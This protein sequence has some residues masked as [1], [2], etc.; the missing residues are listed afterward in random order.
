MRRSRQEAQKRKKPRWHV[1]KEPPF[2]VPV[3]TET[4]EE[5]SAQTWFYYTGFIE[6]ATVVVRHSGDMD[7]LYKMGFFGKGTLSRSEPCFAQRKQKVNLRV[8]SSTS[9]SQG[10][11]VTFNTMLAPVMNKRTYLAHCRYKAL[12]EGRTS[13]FNEISYHEEQQ[14]CLVDSSDE[15]EEDDDDDNAEDE[16]DDYFLGAGGL[17]RGFDPGGPRVDLFSVTDLSTLPLHQLVSLLSQVAILSSEQIATFMEVPYSMADLERKFRNIRSS[18]LRMLRQL[19]AVNFPGRNFKEGEV[20][21]L[22]DDSPTKSGGRRAVGG[23]DD[24]EED[25]DDDDDEDAVVI[26]DSDDE[27]DE[28]EEDSPG[29]SEEGEQES[30]GGGDGKRKKDKEN[31]EEGVGK[32]KEPR[33]GGWSDEEAGDADFWGVEKTTVESGSL[34]DGKKEGI[35]S[36]SSS[37]FGKEGEEKEEATGEDVKALDVRVAEKT[38]VSPGEVGGRER[39]ME[40]EDNSIQRGMEEDEG[41]RGGSRSGG[42]AVD[43]SEGG[44]TDK[45][46]KGDVA[47]ATAD[48]DGGGKDVGADEKDGGGGREGV[49]DDVGRGSGVAADDKGGVKGCEG[50]GVVKDDDSGG[51]GGGGA[52]K[53]EG[54]RKSGGKGDTSKG[55]G[56]DNDDDTKEEKSSVSV[57]RSSG[58]TDRSSK[59]KDGSENDGEGKVNGSS[60]SKSSSSGGGEL[61]TDGGGFESRKVVEAKQ[62]EDAGVSGK[63]QGQDGKSPCRER[64]VDDREKKSNG[65]CFNSVTPDKGG[66]GS[67]SGA[68]TSS[69]RW[70]QNGGERNSMSPS[71]SRQI[72]LPMT[73]SEG[74]DDSLENVAGDGRHGNGMSMVVAAVDDDSSNDS[75]DVI[76]I[77]S[78]SAE[79][80]KLHR[81]LSQPSAGQGSGSTSSAI[82]TRTVQFM[83]SITEQPTYVQASVGFRTW[84][85]VVH[86]NY[87]G[88]PSHLPT[89]MS[90]QEK[91]KEVGGGGGSGKMPHHHH[92][93][94]QQQ[95][96]GG[97]TAAAPAT[98]SSRVYERVFPPIK[99]LLPNPSSQGAVIKQRVKPLP[100]LNTA[101]MLLMN[102]APPSSRSTAPA[103]SSNT[104][105]P[106][107][108]ASSSAASASTTAGFQTLP[109]SAGVSKHFIYHPNKTPPSKLQSRSSKEVGKRSP[110]SGSSKRQPSLSLI[111]LQRYLLAV[112]AVLSC[113]E[114]ND[115][116]KLDEI[117]EQKLRVLSRLLARLD[118]AAEDDR[119]TLLLSFQEKL[120]DYLSLQDISLQRES[121]ILKFVLLKES[122]PGISADVHTRVTDLLSP[123]Q[124]SV[125]GS[126]FE[127]VRSKMP[128][129]FSE[130]TSWANPVSVEDVDMVDLTSDTPSKGVTD[131]DTSGKGITGRDISVEGDTDMDTSVKGD[132]DKDTSV[133]SGPETNEISESVGKTEGERGKDGESKKKEEGSEKEENGKKKK[134]EEENMDEGVKEEDVHHSGKRK[135]PMDGCPVKDEVKKA[136]L[137]E[138]NSSGGRLVGVAGGSEEDRVGKN[139]VGGA[140]EAQSG[141]ASLLNE[142][143]DAVCESDKSGEVAPNLGSC[144]SPSSSVS[145]SGG[146]KSGRDGDEGVV[147]ACES[148]ARRDGGGG[149]VER[150]ASGGGVERLASG[151]G[152]GSGC[153]DDGGVREER[154]KGAELSGLSASETESSSSCPRGEKTASGS[155]TKKEA[156]S[157]IRRSLKFGDG[158]GA[159]GDDDDDD[160]DKNGEDDDDNDDVTESKAVKAAGGDC[161]IVSVDLEDTNQPSADGRN[162]DDSS[163]PQGQGQNPQRGVQGQGQGHPPPPVV[164][165]GAGPGTSTEDQICIGSSSSSEEEE[166]VGEYRPEKRQR[167]KQQRFSCHPYSAADDQRADWDALVVANSSDEDSNSE[168]PASR[169]KW[170][171]CLKQDPCPVEESLHLMLE[172]AFFL[173]FG[174]GCLRIF[175]PEEKLL[176]LTQTWQQFQVLKEQFLPHYVAYHYFRSKGWVPKSGLKFGCDFILYREGPPFYH[177]SYSVV[178]RAV[179]GDTL[180]ACTREDGVNF[181]TRSLS[182][183]SLAGL[184]RITE[185]VAKELMFCYVVWPADL[186]HEEC[187]SPA[188]IAKFKVKEVV[189][190]RWVPSQ[191]RDNKTEE[192]EIP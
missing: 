38:E 60:S 131:R 118:S 67:E 6:G 30:R 37:S 138:G 93:Q 162:S 94:Q 102:R 185:H 182:W 148:S 53:E 123:S 115:P 59:V 122:I 116:E 160:G 135:S 137:S 113:E 117:S 126:R 17:E 95:R 68:S 91:G 69:A 177:G 191:E 9:A 169:A 24:D 171:P 27:E 149:G 62:T 112:G 90:V 189:V 156:D 176:D 183:I 71:N 92:Q 120:F 87:S 43:E 106:S 14:Q 175:D 3:A 13:Q 158:N 51:D 35:S 79:P 4:G 163:S 142:K 100:C 144:S 104:I 109:G 146:S 151:G 119:E 179:K 88:D 165:L 81:F 128:H 99:S 80:K 121:L 140:E 139:A 2:P 187:L 141:N 32:K 154:E 181:D 10:D 98:S 46:V 1:K 86:F 129:L 57:I 134:E 130:G 107:S 101:K 63:G 180:M 39:K 21:T 56:D 61:S 114:M 161:S 192:E 44:D 8:P 125:L 157:T 11:G 20:I 150:L 41:G 186:S 28:E 76:C 64:D 168:A 152:G 50:D 58:D 34:R 190:S 97:G 23:A 84:G 164:G 108:S 52:A 45:K 188:C 85:H 174:L 127:Y 159:D 178:V 184:N 12:Q 7:F 25:D 155:E 173:S 172:E 73:E 47:V 29:K 70:I 96:G 143:A 31:D 153:V 103:P 33:G 82:D 145:A 19:Y 75:D 167:L 5:P 66:R 40:T 48:K 54:E 110:F 42:A 36:S 65:I 147:A 89:A 170:R 49:A 77:E 72:S 22:D 105:L 124:L 111:D 15:D 74:D 55:G 83:S 166:E 26:L 16:G 136:K 78:E 18:E 132:T 133:T